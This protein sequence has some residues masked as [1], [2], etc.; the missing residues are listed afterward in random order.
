ML[1]HVDWY[2]AADTMKSGSAYFF[3]VK[4][5]KK[6]D[7]SWTAWPWRGST[8]LFQNIK[9]VYQVNTVQYARRLELYH[10]CCDN[11]IT[12]RS[13]SLHLCLM[14]FIEPCCW[15]GLQYFMFFVHKIVNILHL[16]SCRHLFNFIHIFLIDKI[17][18]ITAQYV[19]HEIIMAEVLIQ[20]YYNCNL[21]FYM[22][23]FKSMVVSSLTS[24]WIF[25][26][27]FMYFPAG[28]YDWS[29]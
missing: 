24:I 1:C 23:E 13:F 16:I 29:F 25:G 9:T 8:A 27:W 2:I 12:H 18:Y 28:W 7:I 11:I 22:I 21:P 26:F 4:V 3:R 6:N 14:Y 19:T 10:N 20:M 5:S 15:I 17:K